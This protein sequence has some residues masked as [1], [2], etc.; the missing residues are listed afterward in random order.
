MSIM[1]KQ[2]IKMFGIGLPEIEPSNSINIIKLAKSLHQD[3]KRNKKWHKYW[4]N[5]YDAVLI[6]LNKK[7]DLK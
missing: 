2:A 7:E 6:A 3:R 4:V 5:A 1:K